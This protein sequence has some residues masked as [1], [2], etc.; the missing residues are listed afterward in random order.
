MHAVHRNDPWT[1]AEAVR[2]PRVKNRRE[3]ARRNVL[4]GPRT[5][6]L[7]GNDVRTNDRFTSAN[8]L[9]YLYIYKSRLDFVLL[10]NIYIA[11]IISFQLFTHDYI[12]IHINYY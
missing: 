5:D 10:S 6:N 3:T 7:W 9:R 8:R 1:R 12:N 4:P 11:R 2:K